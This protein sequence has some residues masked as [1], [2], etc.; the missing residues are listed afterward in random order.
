MTVVAD[1]TVGGK[2]TVRL[3]LT[4]PRGAPVVSLRIPA[5]ALPESVRMDGELIPDQGGPGKAG[6]PARPQ[7][8][9]RL[10]ILQTVAP[11]GSEVE[12]VLGAAQPMDWYV[13]DQSYDVPPTAQAL[14]AAKPKDAVAAQDGNGTM[15]SR[16]VRI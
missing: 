13:V 2:R 15:V 8:G 1:S 5:A 12:V 7:S 10:Y 4:S 3:R 11:Q 16:K 9:W 14:L 6:A